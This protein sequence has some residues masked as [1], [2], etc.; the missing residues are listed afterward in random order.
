MSIFDTIL[1]IILS[2]FIFYG[3]FYGLIRT[4]GILFGAV[5][6]AVVASR[7]Y[8]QIYNWVEPVFMG[9]ENIGKVIIF[10]ILFSLINRLVGFVFYLLDKTYGLLTI[11]PFLK[12]INRLGGAVLGFITG[13]FFLGMIIFVVSRYSFIEHWLGKWLVDSQMAPFLLKFVNIL[14]PLLPEVLKKLK[15][16]I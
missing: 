6:G 13:G 12:T 15:S 8:V 14:S 1:L 7:F 10:I 11:I 16:L 5:I 2:G 4:I 3:L 9:H